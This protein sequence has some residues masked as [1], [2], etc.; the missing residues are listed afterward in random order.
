M[1]QTA[2]VSFDPAQSAGW[3]TNPLNYYVSQDKGQRVNVDCQGIIAQLRSVPLWPAVLEPWLAPTQRRSQLIAA[4]DPRCRAPVITPA[5]LT[6]AGVQPGQDY[7]LAQGQ[8]DF[9]VRVRALAGVGKLNWYLN[10]RWLQQSASDSWLEIQLAELG[11][12]QLLAIDS[13]GNLALVE[14]ELHQR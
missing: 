2:P 12:Q 1:D 8:Q 11:Q 3:Q 4:A 7:W 10:G 14:F 5:E 9:A 13:A 6:I